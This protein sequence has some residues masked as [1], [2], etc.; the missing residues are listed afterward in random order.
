MTNNAEGVGS[1][2]QTAHYFVGVEAFVSNF[3]K[4]NGHFIG[5]APTVLPKVN[6][7]NNLMGNN[8][9]N[10]TTTTTSSNNMNLSPNLAASNSL[11]HDL[12]GS[13]AGSMLEIVKMLQNTEALVD[14][15]MGGKNIKSRNIGKSP[16]QQIPSPL[17]T[18][19]S[20]TVADRLQRLNADLHQILQYE[21]LSSNLFD[22]VLDGNQNKQN[23]E[24]HPFDPK[25]SLSSLSVVPNVKPM[26]RQSPSEQ[27]QKAFHLA[28][29]RL[30]L[31]PSRMTP[32]I[33]QMWNVDYDV[34]MESTDALR[35]ATASPFFQSFMNNQT[36]NSGTQ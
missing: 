17:H 23:H 34:T 13:D 7:A 24:N 15:I 10:T 27:S 32:I 1:H 16:L 30:N 33:N 20:S 25:R 3:C 8:G 22:D 18:L 31:T 36:N 6:S 5:N 9:A 28:I 4:G 14:K 12:V 26:P 21:S 11:V 2:P 19:K 35:T 29:D